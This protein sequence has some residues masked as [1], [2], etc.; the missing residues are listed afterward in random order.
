MPAHKRNKKKVE[1]KKGE[2]LI[3]FLR[4]FFLPGREKMQFLLAICTNLKIA[5]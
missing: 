3:N 1:E 4:F 2:L 5:I